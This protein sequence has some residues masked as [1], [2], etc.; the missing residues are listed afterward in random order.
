[1]ALPT[2][3]GVLNELLNERDE[4]VTAIETSSHGSEKLFD[5]PGPCGQGE[6]R[7]C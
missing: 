5:D 4:I 1:M 6:P 2:P 3:K 7:G